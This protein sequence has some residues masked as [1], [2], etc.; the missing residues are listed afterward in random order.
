MTTFKSNTIADRIRLARRLAGQTQEE[1]ARALGVTVR[2]YA[3]WENSESTGFMSELDRIAKLF[4]TTAADLAGD[5]AEEAGLG[6]IRTQLA[7][8][9][10]EIRLLRESLGQGS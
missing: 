2:T 10:E 5:P 6:F 8:L 9:T 4:D 1:A 7:D 3:R